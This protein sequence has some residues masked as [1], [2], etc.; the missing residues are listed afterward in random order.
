MSGGYSLLDQEKF[1]MDY[2]YIAASSLQYWEE[3]QVAGS[4]EQWGSSEGATK[5]LPA[6]LRQWS[7]TI[8][9]IAISQSSC[10]SDIEAAVKQLLK[11]QQLQGKN[12]QLQGS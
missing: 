3:P 9:S 5:E 8:S 7:S 4:R 12:Q 6:A 10:N 11:N 2:W 1:Y